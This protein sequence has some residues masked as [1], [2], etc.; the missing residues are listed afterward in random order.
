MLKLCRISTIARSSRGQPCFGVHSGQL[1]W[2]RLKSPPIKISGVPSI[3]KIEFWRAEI[4]D[5]N[6]EL[7]DGRLWVESSGCL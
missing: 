1:T 3:F 6:S 2:G 7:V 4:A 5:L